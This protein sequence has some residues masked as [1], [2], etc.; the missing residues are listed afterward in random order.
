[1]TKRR[2]E[3]DSELPRYSRETMYGRVFQNVCTALS[4]IT[5]V[6]LVPI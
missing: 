4:T 5:K 2:E 1:M 6:S 3:K